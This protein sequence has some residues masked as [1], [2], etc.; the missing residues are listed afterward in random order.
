MATG[1][2]KDGVVSANGTNG[3]T[4]VVASYNEY[5]MIDCKVYPNS[6]GNV[7]I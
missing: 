5:R 6:T 3:E 2:N 4:L 7:K 1:R